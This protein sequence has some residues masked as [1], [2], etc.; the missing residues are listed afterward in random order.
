M[1]I[2]C[3]NCDATISAAI[4]PGTGILDVDG[5]GDNRLRGRAEHCTECGHELDLYYY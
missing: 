4:P 1:R 2:G 5:P 3:P